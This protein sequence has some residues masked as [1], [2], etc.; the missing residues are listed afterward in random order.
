MR[1]RIGDSRTRSLA[2]WTTFTTANGTIDGGD[3]Q[4]FDTTGSGASYAAHFNVGEVNYTPGDFEGWRRL[5]GVPTDEVLTRSRRTLRAATPGN[6]DCGKFVTLM[7]DAP[8]VA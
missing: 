2:P 1:S 7:V 4:M 5:A 8:L 3:V 6:P